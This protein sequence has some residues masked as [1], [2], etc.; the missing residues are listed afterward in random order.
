MGDCWAENK[1]HIVRLQNLTKPKQTF[2]QQIY[3]LTHYSK[4]FCVLV[5]LNRQ[6]INQWL[7]ILLF[8]HNLCKMSDKCCQ[9]DIIGSLK[10]NFLKKKHLAGNLLLV[11][12]KNL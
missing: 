11:L 1:H 7:D 5:V 3:R 9:I 2:F 12:T 10:K 8:R 4:P 6:I